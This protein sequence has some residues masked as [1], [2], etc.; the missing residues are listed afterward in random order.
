MPDTPTLTSVF[1]DIADAIR[2]K[3]GKSDTLTPLEM[4]D[5]ILSISGGGSD[6]LDELLQEEF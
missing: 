2:N 4:P 1:T 6:G 5:E 3:T